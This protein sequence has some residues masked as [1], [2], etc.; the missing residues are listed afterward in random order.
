MWY[1]LYLTRMSYIMTH[2]TLVS[3]PL[4]SIWALSRQSSLKLEPYDICIKSPCEIP[5]GL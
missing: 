3:M 1:S 4:I 5:L 2:S